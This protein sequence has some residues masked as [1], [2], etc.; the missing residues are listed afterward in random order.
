MWMTLRDAVAG[1]HGTE[2]R[3]IRRSRN[4]TMP[5]CRDEAGEAL[6]WVESPEREPSS[7]WSAIRSPARTESETLR[8]RLALSEGDEGETERWEGILGRLRSEL[9]D[10]KAQ[11]RSRLRRTAE[12]LRELRRSARAG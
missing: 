3:L 1:G 11:R 2:S 8:R 6:Y 7:A 9:E 4:G 5:V 10:L 12:R